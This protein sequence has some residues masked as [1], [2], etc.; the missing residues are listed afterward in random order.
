MIPE[1]FAYE[2]VHADDCV[3]DN[4]IVRTDT[5][6]GTT[7]RVAYSSLTDESSTYVLKTV[8]EDEDGR[9]YNQ[10][11]DFGDNWDHLDD[12]LYNGAF[13]IFQTFDEN[14]YFEITVNLGRVKD[15]TRISTEVY[16][17]S[18]SMLVPADLEDLDLPGL[19]GEESINSDSGPVMFNA[20]DVLD[21]LYWIMR[22]FSEDH[23][24]FQDYLDGETDEH[25]L[26]SD[27]AIRAYRSLALAYPFFEGLV[28]QLTD[29]V[30]LKEQPFEGDG[31]IQFRHFKSHTPET[32]TKSLI[33]AL[34]EGLGVIDEYEREFLV[35]TFYNESIDVGVARNDLAH[36][37]FDATRGFQDIAWRELARRLIVSIAFLDEKVA[38]CYSWV[39]AADL[40]TFEQWLAQRERAGFPSLQ[41][42]MR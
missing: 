31:A 16:E 39:D 28:G 32:P 33:N 29:R 42:S 15:T 1:R 17:Q 26:E 36:N 8:D 11:W 13:H 10:Y 24:D 27:A 19:S 6:T 34:E 4:Y 3:G 12:F 9:T 37:I 5:Q 14:Q 2:S 41:G 20:I 40:Q 35:E 23:A 21:E 7:E 25:E 38:C 30:K 18:I 22:E